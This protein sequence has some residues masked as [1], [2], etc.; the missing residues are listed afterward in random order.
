MSTG[1]TTTVVLPCTCTHAEQ[2][3]VHGR[4]RRVHNRLGK[5]R[6]E[7]KDLVDQYRCTVCGTTRSGRP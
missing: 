5:G 6:G 2:D 4:A 1:T 3:A 7:G